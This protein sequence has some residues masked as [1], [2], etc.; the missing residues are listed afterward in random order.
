[1]G[2]AEV[3][4]FVGMM[5]GFGAALVGF[6]GLAHDWA[7]TV[8]ASMPRPLPPAPPPPPPVLIVVARTARGKCPVCAQSVRG[9]AV[10]CPSCRVPMHGDCWKYQGGCGI[11]ACERAISRA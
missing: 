3:A 4:S 8:A 6:G 5:V 11:Y 7:R 1:V 10:Q 9:E 2:V